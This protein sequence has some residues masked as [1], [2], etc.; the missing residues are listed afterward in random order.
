MSFSTARLTLLTL[1]LMFAVTMISAQIGYREQPTVTG[2]QITELDRRV[3]NLEENKT[4]ARLVRIET[5]LQESAK[6]SEATRETMVA[7]LVPV[8]LLTLEALFRL[9][10]A[11]PLKKKS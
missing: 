2:T 6:S 7:V 5:L 8:C 4:E 9:G 11:L 1:A 3:A 10:S